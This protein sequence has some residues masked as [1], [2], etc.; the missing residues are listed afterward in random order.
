MRA[1]RVIT[2]ALVA[3]FSPHRSPGP[4]LPGPDARLA[5]GPGRGGPR[6]P[7]HSWPGICAHVYEVSWK[8]RLV[9]GGECGAET[10]G[11]PLSAP[12][13]HLRSRVCVQ[14]VCEPPGQQPPAW[15]GLPTK[16]A[17]ARPLHFPGSGLCS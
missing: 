11:W 5:S 15:S 7:S 14:R 13:Y 12:A 3:R 8:Q 6:P 10:P 2:V 16:T 1:G 4:Q 9:P 17:G